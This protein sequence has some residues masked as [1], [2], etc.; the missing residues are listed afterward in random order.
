MVRASG[1]RWLRHAVV[2]LVATLI[3]CGGGGGAPD[4]STAVTVTLVS[5]TQPYTATVPSRRLT[6]DLVLVGQASGDLSTLN[7][8]TLW[9]F[10]ED[11]AGLFQPEAFTSVDVHAGTATINLFGKQLSTAGRFAGTL[12][13]LVCLDAACRSQLKGSPLMLPY[14]VTVLPGLAV[15]SHSVAVTSRFGNQPPPATL[16][17]T[18]PPNAGVPLLFPSRFSGPTA[19]SFFTT[20]AVLTGPDTATVTLT[21]ERGVPGVYV[22]L[23]LVQVDGYS[24]QVSVTLTVEDDP[25]LAVAATPRSF[26]FTQSALDST[27]HAIAYDMLTRPGD[28]LLQYL[29]IAYVESPPAAAGHPQHDHWLFQDVAAN[30]LF[31]V[32]CGTAPTPD[33]LPAGTYRA[34]ARWQ[35]Q[36]AD[37]TVVDFEVPITLILTP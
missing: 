17:A 7:G 16:T 18:L 9:V 15:S 27:Q 13:V 32:S 11:A 33:C 14:D 1:L 6:P 30:R 23:L 24:E 31:T 37:G 34:A 22:G 10:V 29:G 3:A 8:R 2:A 26:E 5:P 4:A 19:A 12:R 35:I 28:T 21:F 25:T 36:R 20:S